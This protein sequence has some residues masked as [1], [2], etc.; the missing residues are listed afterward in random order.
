MAQCTDV[1]AYN[2]TL[3]AFRN[4]TR[5]LELE[6]ILKVF[7]TKV[8]QMVRTAPVFRDD[9]PVISRQ[10]LERPRIELAKL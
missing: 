10:T 6:E 1:S 3:P 9:W 5:A 4:S 7:S 2:S 8:A